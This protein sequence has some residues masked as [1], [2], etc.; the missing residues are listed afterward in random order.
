MT[1]SLKVERS[2]RKHR[3]GTGCSKPVQFSDPDTNK[4]SNSPEKVSV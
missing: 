2:G 4:N 3:V 1:E